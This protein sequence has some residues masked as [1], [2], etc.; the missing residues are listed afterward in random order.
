MEATLPIDGIYFDQ[1]SAVPPALCRNREH[2]HKPG[3]GSYW[4]DGYNQ[5][6]EKINAAKPVDKFYFS[7]SNA[8]VYAKSF[9]GFL[10]W[11]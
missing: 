1:V 10:T 3:G 2:S 8:E 5:M 6:M 7:E 11:V 9:D 4:S